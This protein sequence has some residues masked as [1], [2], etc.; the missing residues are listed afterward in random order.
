MKAKTILSLLLLSGLIN[1]YGQN[2]VEKE[3]F[4]ES[5]NLKKCNFLTTGSNQYFILE[6]GY[7]LQLQGIGGKDTVRLLITVLNETKKVGDIETRIVEEH[8][9]VNG[10][11]IEISRNYFAF[12]KETGSIFYFGEDVDM[13]KDGQIMNHSGAWLA[14]G[15]NKAG[16][17][18]PG[19]PLIGSKYYQE[20]APE[21]A[22]DRVEITSISDTLDTQ[23]GKFKNVLST[24]ETTPLEPKDKSIK[25]YAPGVGLIKDDHLVII[26]YGFKN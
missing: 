20:I 1:V 12:C 19:L 26:K 24:I 25:Q 16:L 13:Y 11:V 7:Q 9:S 8:E 2:K 14:E 6:P 22:M 4:T 3:N 15:K 21:I 5:F 18:M 10:Q 17:M 23:A